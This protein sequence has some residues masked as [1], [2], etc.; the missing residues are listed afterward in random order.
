MTS[1]SARRLNEDNE[2]IIILDLKQ[3]IGTYYIIIKSLTDIIYYY[4]VMSFMSPRIVE[5]SVKI[6]YLLIT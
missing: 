6:V 2:E 5:N 3:L 1:A 4:Y